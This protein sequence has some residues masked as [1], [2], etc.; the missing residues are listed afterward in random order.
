M[1]YYWIFS[2]RENSRYMFISENDGIRVPNIKHHN[3]YLDD[4]VGSINVYEITISTHVPRKANDTS[5]EYIY[6]I[7]PRGADPFYVIGQDP[8]V[9]AM[10]V[11]TGFTIQQ[12]D[13]ERV[14]PGF[15]ERFN[16]YIQWC[17]WRKNRDA[18]LD[19]ETRKIM[20]AR[21]ELN[22]QNQEHLMKIFAN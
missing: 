6:R 19:A 20:E 22:A 1:P 2:G 3:K 17:E 4:H 18:E 16:A 10:F 9:R 5:P 21:N 11:A 12:H 7:I 14:T 8:S 13:L 15:R